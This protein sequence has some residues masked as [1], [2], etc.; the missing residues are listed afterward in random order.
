MTQGNLPMEQKGT[1]P[2][3]GSFR[4]LTLKFLNTGRL[5]VLSELCSG[6]VGLRLRPVGGR[7]RVVFIYFVAC[8]YMVV[9]FPSVF[10]PVC[11]FALMFVFLRFVGST[12][13]WFAYAAII[14]SADRTRWAPVTST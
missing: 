12:T 2:R 10:F 9:L 4:S 13:L 6:I 1:V 7:S 5:L 3:N 14:L 8:G 11:S